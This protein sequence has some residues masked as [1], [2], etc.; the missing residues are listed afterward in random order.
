ML[1]MTSFKRALRTASKISDG[2]AMYSLPVSGWLRPFAEIALWLWTLRGGQ[3]AP[4]W[5]RH[6]WKQPVN[7]TTEKAREQKCHGFGSDCT[8]YKIVRSRNN[9]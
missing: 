3:I 1:G 6:K 8:V 7:I 9:I 5:R 2:N 4:R